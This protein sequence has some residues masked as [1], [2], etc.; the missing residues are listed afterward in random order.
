MLIQLDKWTLNLGCQH[1]P[2]MKEQIQSARAYIKAKQYDDARRILKKIDHPTAKEWLRK[3][4]EIDPPPNI[5]TPSK[6]FLAWAQ[7]AIA[8]IGAGLVVWLVDVTGFFALIFRTRREVE[9]MLLF[10]FAISFAGFFYLL[11]VYTK[12][13]K[14]K[15]LKPKVD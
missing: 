15:F 13:L 7:M 5:N 1:M 8:A 12:Q 14:D 11:V 9:N 2:T 6:L 3:I 10:I 4:D